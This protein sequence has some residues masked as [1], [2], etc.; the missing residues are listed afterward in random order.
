MTDIAVIAVISVVVLSLIA[1]GL[2]LL[3]SPDVRRGYLAT[4]RAIRWWM[5]PVAVAHVLLILFSLNLLLTAVPV[6]Q[7]GWW[8]LLGGS[9]NVAL[10]QT[11]RD[12]SLW[13]FIAI[14]V[15]LAVLLQILISPTT[16]SSFSD[17]GA[18]SI[19][20]GSGFVAR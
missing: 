3:R 11:G 17:L 20:G 19:R 6:L 8:M 12:G 9:G 16:K 5:W 4:I 14:A 2:L 13:Q 18:S 15:P 7:L 10:G 1:G